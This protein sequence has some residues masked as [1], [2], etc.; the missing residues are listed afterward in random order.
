MDSQ[1]MKTRVWF[2]NKLDEIFHLS[3]QYFS[4]ISRISLF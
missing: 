4:L 2:S 3:A 1:K